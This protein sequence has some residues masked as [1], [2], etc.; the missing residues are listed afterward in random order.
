M[1]GVAS[2]DVAILRAL[3]AGAWSP[4]WVKAVL[5]VTFLGSGWMM[6]PLLVGFFWRGW[7]AA[8][9]AATLLLLVTAGVVAAIKALAPRARPCQ[10]LAWAHALSLDFP[11]DP[12]FPSGHSAGS[13]AFAFFVLGLRPRVGAPLVLLAALVAASRVALGVHY[14]SDVTAGA[15]LGA[16]LGTLGARVYRDLRERWRPLETS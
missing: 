9:A 5:A 7:R 11:T 4:V 3:Y 2:L 10:A 1:G 15:A 12:S 8:S 14:P 6:L 16:V 13:F